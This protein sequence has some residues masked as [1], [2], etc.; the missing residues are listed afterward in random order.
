MLPP[1]G[2]ARRRRALFRL[3][4]DTW[5]L[6]FQGQRATLPHRIG[7]TYLRCLLERP[8]A[9]IPAIELA[10]LG[11]DAIFVDRGV[12]AL[13]DRKAIAE[14]HIGSPRS[15]PRSRPAGARGGRQRRRSSMNAR[16]ARRTSAARTELVSAA[17]RARSGVT[18]AIKRALQA[19]AAC[20]TLG[21][22][23]DRRIE[24]GRLCVYIPDPAAPVTFEF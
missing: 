22:H 11:G 12:G 7:M 4:E 8:G 21:H 20:T 6:E 3:A 9:P 19:I 23:L 13:V 18:K 5:Q 2:A 1:H 14:V 15:T 10:S 16:T 17:E 24:T